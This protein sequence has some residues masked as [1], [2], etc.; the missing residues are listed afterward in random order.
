MS[1]PVLC[2]LACFP[3]NVLTYYD[4]SEPAAFFVAKRTFQPAPRNKGA[5]SKT[6]GERE[7]ERDTVL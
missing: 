6:E 7:A 3:I 1:L 5:A 2:Y 4:V